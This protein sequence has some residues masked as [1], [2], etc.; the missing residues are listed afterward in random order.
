MHTL[1][2]MRRR[3][4]N[5][6][7][8]HGVVRVMKA[9]AAVSIRQCEKAVESL[10]HY[11]EA[12]EQGFQVCL[13]NQPAGVIRE[14]S[15]AAGR[16]GVVL[17]GSDQGM[18]GSFNEQIV[19]FALGEMNASGTP[20]QC[21]RTIVAVGSRVVD[22]LADAGF[23]VED[24]FPV[25]SSVAGIATVVHGLLPHVESLLADGK[26]DR[27]E[28]Y[29]NHPILGATS[30]P[31]K[32]QLLPL[33][34]AWLRRLERKPWP[35]R[36]LPMIT[37]DWR[38]LFAALVRQ[39]LF[40]ALYQAFA[41]SLASENASRLSSMQAAEKNI[42]DHLAALTTHYH[43]Q[44]QQSITEELLDIVAGFETLTAEEHR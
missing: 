19:S 13:R 34:S 25:P 17:F 7:D 44:R 9:L 40:V 20:S 15:R 23:P 16:L 32:Q 4:E 42:E 36:S 35:S 43:Q 37:L 28:L 38:K 29:H 30:S 8:L 22:R 18:C 10:R 27:L 6:E 12:I 14:D 2:S 5:A 26:I 11:S 3:I 31:R 24:Q 1:E 39:Y 21:Q 41:E 33:D